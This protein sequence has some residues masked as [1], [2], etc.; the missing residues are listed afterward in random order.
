MIVVLQNELQTDKAVVLQKWQPQLAI[1]SKKYWNS[2]VPEYLHLVL[3]PCAWYSV[4]RCTAIRPG[5]SD[6]YIL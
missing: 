4:P 3:L 1:F 6:V 2:R 5:A